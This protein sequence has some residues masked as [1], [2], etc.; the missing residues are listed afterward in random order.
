MVGTGDHPFGATPTLAAS[1]W[2]RRWGQLPCKTAT[3][4]HRTGA[5]LSTGEP[6]Q[7]STTRD[8]RACPSGSSAS[9]C[10]FSGVAPVAPRLRGA[11]A[12]LRGTLGGSLRLSEIRR[13][14]R[15]VGSA[16]V[17]MPPAR[18]GLNPGRPSL[19]SASRELEHPPARPAGHWRA[20]PPEGAPVR[21]SAAGAMPPAIELEPGRVAVA[22]VRRG[23]ATGDAEHGH[24]STVAHAP[25]QYKDKSPS[26]HRRRL[27]K[28][29]VRGITEAAP[30]ESRNI[31]NIVSSELRRSEGG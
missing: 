25:C 18:I 17:G 11:V 3:N 16:T 2:P 22:G 20:L 28:T 5:K 30:S 24:A 4:A 8:G 15:S 1:K 9:R 19:A 14:P 21:E 23:V 12:R 13:E 29:Q 6:G 7:A 10:P 26:G 31:G 27:G